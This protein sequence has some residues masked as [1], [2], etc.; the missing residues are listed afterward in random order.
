M[1]SEITTPEPQDV[2]LCFQMETRFSPDQENSTSKGFFIS[3]TSL[4]DYEDFADS[5][6]FYQIKEKGV[7]V[8]YVIALPPEHP[9][10]ARLL[11]AKQLFSLQ[12][13]SV[14][15]GEFFW[16]AKVA[17]EET[18]RGKGLARRLYEQLFR[19][20]PDASFMTASLLE[21][22]RNEASLGF[23][24]ALG[25]EK[26]GTLQHKSRGDLGDCVSQIFFRQ[27]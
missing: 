16:I 17:V 13:P 2:R 27:P 1:P 12:D 8:A 6:L 22:L 3:G 18:H 21:P 26:I 4:K 9:R 14:L 11:E 19:E 20:N 5:A 7:P 24:E 10:L 25:F 23:H 15:D